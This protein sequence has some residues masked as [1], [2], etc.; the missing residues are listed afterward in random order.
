MGIKP[1]VH[2]IGSTSLF[3]LSAKPVIDMIGIIKDPE[4]AIK[5]LKDL[6]FKYRGEYN[7]PM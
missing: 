7:N 3:G 5:S 6:D 2:H 4:M 1:I